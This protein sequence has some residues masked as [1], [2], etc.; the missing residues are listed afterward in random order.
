MHTLCA[1]CKKAHPAFP[2]GACFICNNQ[3]EQ[4]EEWIAKAVALLGTNERFVLSTRVP[5]QWLAREEELLDRSLN[6]ETIKQTVNQHI[7]AALQS[8]G[9]RYAME[10]PVRLEMDFFHGLVQVHREPRFFFGRYKKFTLL[11]QSR[12]ICKVCQGKGCGECKGK[13]KYYDAVEEVIGEPFKQ[14]SKAED[15][16]LHAS[17]RED[18][19]ALNTA[20]RPFVLEL[21]NPEERV[22]VPAVQEEINRS[23]KV[24]VEGMRIVRRNFVTLIGDSHFDKEYEAEVVL[25]K[26]IDKERVYELEKKVPLVLEQQ[27]PQRVAH[28]RADLVRKREVKK[29]KI[30][31][32][33]GTRA[34]VS[35]TAEA[36]TYI[37][38]F[39]SGDDGRTNPSMSALLG[40]G[41]RCEKLTVTKIY[42]GFLELVA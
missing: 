23:G 13:G 32:C 10:A 35:V 40:T 31:G 7:V 16:I 1:F 19:D 15:Y 22:D 42:D 34:H 17:G 2:P 33:E 5:K 3:L 29:L 26:P 25:E 20:G 24:K 28:R 11:S 8:Q 14:A 39:I 37:K 38:E 9:K 18:V 36:G 6:A 12:W 4:L 41:V 30:I 21:V 27:T